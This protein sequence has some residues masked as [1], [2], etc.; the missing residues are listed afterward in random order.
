[1][2]PGLSVQQ[3]FEAYDP[4]NA[5]RTGLRTVPAARTATMTNSVEPIGSDG[6][7]ARLQRL[8]SRIEST[9]WLLGLLDE[10]MEALREID[11]KYAGTMATDL[12]REAFQDC[13]HQ[14]RSLRQGHFEA[15]FP[16]NRLVY[17]LTERTEHA[18]LATSVED[19]DLKWWQ[20][21]A[22]HTY[23]RLHKDALRR[24][25]RVQRIFIY[26][27]WTDEHET[28]ARKQQDGGVR[29]LRVNQEQ[30]S[31]DLRV[32]MILWDE[33]CGYESRL[34]SSGEAITNSYTFAKEELSQMFDKYKV[35]E[36]CAE[37][38]PPA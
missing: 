24:G 19:V 30:L 27:A 26:R 16:D 2:F 34:N 10:G 21:A 35:I 14:L 37:E 18:L 6:G 15:P 11:D 12:C 7:G 8:L 1:M 22:G 9:P 33:S 17:A 23:W 38:W 32:D 36:L 31:P 25:V 28:L 29:T 3:L 13:V 5:Q 4:D 20:S